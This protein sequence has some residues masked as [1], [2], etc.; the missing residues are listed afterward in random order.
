MIKRPS[1][2]HLWLM[3]L[4][5]AGFTQVAG[6]VTV[7][8]VIDGPQARPYLPMEFIERE[9]RDLLGSEFDI[10]FPAD[11]RIDGGWT[12]DGVRAAIQQQLADPEVDIV[13]TLGVLA[14][15]A[16][17]STDGL[18]KPVVADADLQQFPLR[19]GVSGKPNFVYVSSFHSID[20]QIATFIEAV[21]FKRLAVLA[22]RLTLE[23][24]PALQTKAQQLRDRFVIRLDVI[25]V[26]D[27][28]QQAISALPTDTDAVYVS[29][30]LR[31]DREQM[32][33]LAEG[34]IERR[35]PS[36]S[37][38]GG[39][40]LDA[41][42]LMTS[43]GRPGDTT[44]LARRLALDI[45][46][47]LLGE[48]AADIEVSFRESKRLA[49]NMKTAKAIDFSPRYAILADAIR[50]YDD[51]VD[52]GEKMS[53]IEAMRQALI[54]NL[55]LRSAALGPE[56]AQDET[57]VAR[58]RLLP[59]IGV[60]V[61]HMRIDADRGNPLFQSERSSDAELQASQVLYSEDARAAYD[62]AR[63]LERSSDEIYRAAVLDI[64]RSSS[65][66][67]L[68][69]LRAKAFE[70]VQRSNL[71][72]TRAN[73]ELA[74]LRESIGFSGRADVLR[75]ESQIAIDRQNLIAAEAD[76]R[77]AMTELNRVLNRSL[78]STIATP[79]NAVASSLRVF[80]DTRFQAFIWTLLSKMRCVARPSC[81]ASTN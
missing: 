18:S 44:K 64:L 67:Y 54:A 77:K 20:D 2:R 81:V 70:A 24:I 46:R 45:Q 53:L 50:L 27:S 47:I 34:L 37:L 59:Q 74:Q 26:T 76:R 79:E 69:V 28:V 10:E 23:S 13:L 21:G 58:S 73:L 72:V 75:W 55:S 11:K 32:R 61:G 39:A 1:V 35:L 48:N 33:L 68:Q 36:F 15:N 42:L 14:S 6:A 78:T 7:G 8:V 66:S 57:R 52:G 9:A 51:E 63:A 38:L 40:E 30:L 25:A 71:E 80:D 3:V 29:P 49:I 22:D 4:A 16:A 19:N 60:S 5:C 31:F 41:G 12:L 56:I 62:I 17:A 65:S 43:S